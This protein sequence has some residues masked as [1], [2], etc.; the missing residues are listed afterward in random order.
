MKELQFLNKYFYKYKYQLLLGILITIIARVFSLVMPEY[1]QYS[2][3]AVEN[4]ILAGN[5]DFEAVK[6]KLI[7]YI[8]I[9]VGSAFLSGIF[10]FWMRQTI[11]NISRYIEFD[12]KNE[13]FKQYERLSQNFYKKNRTGDLMN[14]VSEDVSRV[15]MYAGPA[16]MYSVQTVTLFLCVIPLMFYT[17]PILALYTLIPLPILSVLIYYISRTI[18]KRTTVVQEYLSEL[19]TF[20]QETFSGIGVIKAYSIEGRINE[21]VHRLAEEGKEKSMHLAKVQAWFFLLCFC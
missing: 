10:T 7:N 12:L 16:I 15:R 3:D 2:L 21:D 17:S 20:S 18:H 4:H 11:I 14:R 19:S 8:L 9:I 1:V 5:N 6:K 13:I